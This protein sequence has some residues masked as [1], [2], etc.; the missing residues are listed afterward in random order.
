MEDLQNRLAEADAQAATLRS[1]IA[2]REREVRAA[3]DRRA[4]IENLNKESKQLESQIEEMKEYCKTARQ[5]IDEFPTDTQL[6][7]L[8]RRLESLKNQ[9]K[10]S[11]RAVMQRATGVQAYND[12]VKVCTQTRVSLVQDSSD[13]LQVEQTNSAGN[14]SKEASKPNLEAIHQAIDALI[15]IA[16]E[17]ENDLQNL[18]QQIAERLQEQQSRS[19]KIQELQQHSDTELPKL[20]AERERDAQELTALW[21]A[22]Y[23]H[24]RSTYTRLF[25]VNK[26][27]QFHLGRGT[28]IKKEPAKSDLLEEQTQSALQAKLASEVNDTTARLK[29]IRDELRYLKK[30]TDA[31][32][33]RGRE[34]HARFEQQLNVL[35]EKEKAAE[36]ERNDVIEEARLLRDVKGELSSVLMSIRDS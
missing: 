16:Q 20:A 5:E 22:E 21:N 4:K 6:L 23:E 12:R 7:K 25:A 33:E 28:H 19:A 13:A 10:E 36:K 1:S 31:V 34:A 11:E 9:V 2:E 35:Q 18:Q 14:D 8:E 3:Q 27:Q 29:D 26:E 15:S 32:R 30:Q 24:L 17:R